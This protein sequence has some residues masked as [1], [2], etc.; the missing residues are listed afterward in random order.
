MWRG[1][2]ERR[3]QYQGERTLVKAGKNQD[4][5]VDMGDPGRRANKR[6]DDLGRLGGRT[7]K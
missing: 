2:R 4:I 5:Q 3:R 7:Y 1:W 6:P